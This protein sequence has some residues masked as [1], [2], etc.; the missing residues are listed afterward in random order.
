MQTMQIHRGY[1]KIKDKFKSKCFDFVVTNYKKVSSDKI[2]KPSFA[3]SNSSCHVN[4]VAAVSGERAD[5]VWMVWGGKNN[6]CVHF[7]NSISGV[8]FDETWAYC[9]HQSYYIIR[10]VMPFEFEDIG[11]L[12]DSS[13][14]ML[15]N[16]NGNLIERFYARRNL[17]RW[18]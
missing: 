15:I 2:K 7:I 1:M 5:K 8:F 18:I 14:R 12:L 9:E 16:L 6:G 13:K 17:H 11:D 10:Q 4:A 3:L